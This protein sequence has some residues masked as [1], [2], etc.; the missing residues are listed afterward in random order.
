MLGVGLLLYRRADVFGLGDVKLAFLIGAFSGF[1]LS[2]RAL[3]A[4][5]VVGG[6]FGIVLVVAGRSTRATM[7]Y[8]PALAVGAYLTWLLTG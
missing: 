2:L 8:G 4:G 6:V 1:P 7:P 5:V 3:I